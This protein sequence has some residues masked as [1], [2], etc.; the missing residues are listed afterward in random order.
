MT[1]YSIEAVF[2]AIDQFTAPLQKMATSSKLFSGTLKRD[3]A[4]AQREADRFVNNFSQ[5]VRNG[6]F[7]GVGLLAA[8]AGYAIKEGIKLASDLVEVQ[9]VVDTTFQGSNV[10]INQWSKNA[11]SKFG[12]SELQAKQFNGT[13]GAMLKSSGLS[14]DAIVK[15][16]TDMVGLAGDFASFY[17]LDA[18]TAFQKI[19]S[20]ISGETEPLKQ[21]GINMSETNLQAFALSEGI[22]KNWKSM[23]QAD[24]VMVRYNYLMKMSK[25]A[26]GDFAKTLA[27]SWANQERVLKTKFAQKLAESMSKLLPILIEGGKWLNNLIDQFDAAKF[28]DD[29]EKLVKSLFGFFKNIIVIYNIIK[30][31]IPL[32]LSFIAAMIVYNKVMLAAAIIQNIFS[33]KL[34]IYIILIGILIFLIYSIMTNWNKLNTTQKTLLIILGSVIAAIGLLIGIVMIVKN[35][36]LIWT[37]VQWALNI[38]MDAN[39]IGLIVIGIALLIAGIVLLIVYWKQISTV[40]MDFYEKHKVLFAIFMPGLFLFIEILKMIVKNWDL[41]KSAAM[42]VWNVVS[43]FV[44][45]SISGFMQMGAMI[46]DFLI[47]PLQGF[48]TLLSKIPGMEGLSK[49]S[50]GIENAKQGLYQ[51]PLTTRESISKTEKTTKGELTITDKSGKAKLESQKQ[52]SGYKIKMQSSGAF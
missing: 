45:D 26:Q 38:A 35:A 15:L 6:V 52:N 51:N 19:R 25:D 20:G 30:P 29:I 36:Y 7:I 10:I 17:N 31:F 42:S 49:I 24:K 1:K 41:I 23:T 48:L 40:V 47:T 27:T 12:L 11:I 50:L 44:M 3:F 34:N 22:T 32:I 46:F 5:T 4:K 33:K 8:G 18:E 13:M 21:L 39:P 9:N 37:A 14:G 2:R 43:G 28:A 16:S